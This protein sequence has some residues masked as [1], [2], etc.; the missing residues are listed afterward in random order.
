MRTLD[1]IERIVMPPRE[2]FYRKYVLRQKPVIVTNLFAGQPIAGIRSLADAREVLGTTTLEIREEY[3]RDPKAPFSL[4]TLSD[5]LDL[6]ARDPK[7]S[8]MCIEYDTPARVLSLFDLPDVCKTSREDNDLFTNLFVGKKENVAHLHFDGDQRHVLLHEVLG[9]KRVTL[10][11][12]T[13]A[14]KLLPCRNFATF[15]L[16][17]LSDADKLAFVTYC[18]GWDAVVAPGETIFIPALM[19]HHVEYLDEVSLGYNLRFGRH[20]Y[21][22]FLSVENFHLD[23][24][25]QNVG[26][27]MVDERVAEA[28]Y[29]QV[30]ADLEAAL[31]E[32]GDTLTKYRL[33]RDL[34]RRIYAEHCKDAIKADLFFD[35]LHD[36]E[37]KEIMDRAAGGALYVDKGPSVAAAL[38][39]PI[40]PLQK[41]R[42]TEQM[43]KRGLSS[44]VAR[45]VIANRFGKPSLD[46]LSKAE[47]ARLLKYLSSNSALA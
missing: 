17:R 12:P 10:I 33:M 27:L 41:Q 21:S 37:E 4:M 14:K 9:H 20:K 36:R 15:A 13:Q 24:Y 39:G 22:R 26:W 18:D 7:T 3:H 11:R 5:Y 19:W 25:V 16:E 23:M 45:R 35:P 43:T 34:F 32:P 42:V 28:E 40:S 44:E 29:A 1:N 31:G 47:A 38:L 30:F 6:V 2:E 8:L 46:A